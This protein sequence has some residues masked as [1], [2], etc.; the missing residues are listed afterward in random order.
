MILFI[1]NDI[2]QLIHNTIEKNEYEMVH[3][4]FNIGS[5]N[6]GKLMRLSFTLVVF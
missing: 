1:I 5:N 3:T 2:F 6:L 4:I